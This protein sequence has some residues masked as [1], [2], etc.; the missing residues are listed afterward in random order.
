MKVEKKNKIIKENQINEGNLGAT[1]VR[2]LT[3]LNHI[4]RKEKN[5]NEL[6][7]KEIEKIKLLLIKNRSNYITYRTILSL[8]NYI[9]KNKSSNKIHDLSKINKNDKKSIK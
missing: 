5:L 7:Y 1:R 9:L 8:L 3:I 4:F 6:D 2:L